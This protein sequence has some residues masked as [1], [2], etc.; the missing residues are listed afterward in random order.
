MN[1][2]DDIRAAERSTECQHLWILK[3]DG[4]IYCYDCKVRKDKK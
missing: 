4:T 1:W 3:N 2:F